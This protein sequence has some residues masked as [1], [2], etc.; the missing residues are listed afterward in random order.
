[1]ATI[2]RYI[3]SI[4]DVSLED[5]TSAISFVAPL[6]LIGS[7]GSPLYKLGDLHD[8]GEV[9]ETLMDA[10]HGGYFTRE[11]VQRKLMSD[12]DEDFFDDFFSEN[13][14][15]L[16]RDIG[17]GREISKFSLSPILKDVPSNTTNL[18]VND[19]LSHIPFRL[20]EVRVR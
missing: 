7:G 1:M 20:I 10:L 18:S 3:R 4:G 6:P 11:I 2:F 19:L 8:V 15:F 5:V 13:V 16:V 9:M 17:E 14:E 12:E